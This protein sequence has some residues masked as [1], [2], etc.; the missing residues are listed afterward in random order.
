MVF[1]PLSEKPKIVNSKYKPTI[2]RTTIPPNKEISKTHNIPNN[3]P[4]QNILTFNQ[5]KWILQTKHN[6]LQYLTTP[7]L[8]KSNWKPKYLENKLSINVL[9]DNMLS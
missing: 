7:N 9:N 5:K 2:L 8:Q 3:N 1:L 6:Q 4:K